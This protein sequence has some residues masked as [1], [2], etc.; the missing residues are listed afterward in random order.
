MDGC[1]LKSAYGG[2]Y[3]Y[4]EKHVYIQLR[5]CH[6]EQPVQWLEGVIVMQ[7]CVWQADWDADTAS[8][9]LVRWVFYCVCVCVS[10]RTGRKQSQPSN[11]YLYESK[12]HTNDSE[13]NKYN[14]C[15]SALTI[16]WVHLLR[17]SILKYTSLTDIHYSLLFPTVRG[18]KEEESHR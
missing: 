2:F 9:A 17:V 13:D 8:L 18:N 15:L 10:E 16:L 5:L 12:K 1:S 11:I 6:R 3:S 7:S 4:P 14:G